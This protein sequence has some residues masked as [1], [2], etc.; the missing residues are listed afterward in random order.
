MRSRREIARAA[1][2]AVAVAACGTGDVGRPS[3]PSPAATPDAADSGAPPAIDAATY[4]ALSDRPC[5]KGSTLD[6]DNFGG[7]FVLTWCAGCHS[8]ALPEG[9][10]QN[11]PITVNFDHVED[12]RAHAARIWARAA[13]DNAQMPPAGGPNASDREQL[14]EWLACG[15]P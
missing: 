14:G 2:F 7:P 4:K 9:S 3:S 5:P 1:L 13:D 15:A 10:R 6:Y 8:A 12:V 11:A